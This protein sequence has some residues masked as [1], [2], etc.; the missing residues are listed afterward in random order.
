MALNYLS[1]ETLTSN[2]AYGFQLMHPLQRILDHT[3][4]TKAFIYAL[5]SILARFK[6]YDLSFKFHFHER[7]NACHDLCK[8]WDLFHI[9][10]IGNVP[11]LMEPVEPSIHV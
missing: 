11:Q 2:K 6:I 8:V 7:G 5:F 1:L 4:S 3:C 10:N 9:H